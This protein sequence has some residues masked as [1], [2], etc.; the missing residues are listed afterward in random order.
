MQIV[1]ILLGSLLHW[2]NQVLAR[3]SQQTAAWERQLIHREPLRLPPATEA[4]EEPPA[5]WRRLVEEAIP[6]EPPAAWVELVERYRSN[7]TEHNVFSYHAP[8]A[9]ANPSPQQ[10][11]R[12]LNRRGSSSKRQST[13]HKVDYSVRAELNTLRH[14]LFPRR[15]AGVMPHQTAEHPRQHPAPHDS[16]AVH[17]TDQEAARHVDPEVEAAHPM[18][19]QPTAS[20]NGL[21]FHETRTIRTT[22]PPVDRKGVRQR[23]IDQPN[24]TERRFILR[25]TPTPPASPAPTKVDSAERK[26]PPSPPTAPSRSSSQTLPAHLWPSL[27]KQR[28]PSMPPQVSADQAP[29]ASDRASDVG[30]ANAAAAQTDTPTYLPAMREQTQR[31][32]RPSQSPAMPPTGAKSAAQT[33]GQTQSAFQPAVTPINRDDPS[34]P[35]SSEPFSIAPSLF[36]SLP[37]DFTRTDDH[38]PPKNTQRLERES[39]QA[40]EREQ[41]DRRR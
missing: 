3:W 11:Q 10:K 33:G 25:P 31:A 12:T 36:P 37:D 17:H 35:Y 4:D 19:Q 38:V 9:P 5:A 6:D 21:E 2:L 27:P 28:P 20:P 32:A 30:I 7:E 26:T 16:T 24:F 18:H 14:R 34:N 41:R 39:R 23:E 1:T 15:A 8:D 13:A 22:P 29:S 40:L